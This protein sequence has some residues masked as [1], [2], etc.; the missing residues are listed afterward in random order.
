[1]SLPTPARLP[2]VARLSLPLLLLAGVLALARPAAAQTGADAAAKPPAGRVLPGSRFDIDA[3]LERPYTPEVPFGG[4]GARLWATSPQGW[5]FPEGV[6]WLALTDIPALEL[7]VADAHSRLRPT[8]ATS[9]PSHVHLEGAERTLTATASSGHRA[10]DLQ[11]PLTPPFQPEKRWTSGASG[12]RKDWY[13]VSFGAPRTLR[14]LK[15]H[16]VDD[17]GTG[18]IRPPATV[19]VEAAQP[20]GTWAPVEVAATRPAK[21]AVGANELTFAAPVTAEQIRVVFAR[22]GAKDVTG[23]AGFEPLV[24]GDAPPAPAVKLVADKFLTPDD[25]LVTVLRATNPTDQPTTLRV[26]PV[27]GWEGQQDYRIL[28]NREAGKDGPAGTWVLEGDWRTRYHGFD[29]RQG[30]RFAVTSEPAV[31]QEIHESL[32]VTLADSAGR[33]DNAGFLRARLP[34]TYTLAPGETKIFR[35]A[36][37]FKRPEEPSTLDRVLA[38]SATFARTRRE[39]GRLGTLAV[40]KQDQRD[41]LADQ[42]QATAAWFDASVPYFDCSDE[43]VRKLYY[44]RAFLLRKNLLDPKL[45]ALKHPTFSAGR[46]RSAWD[47]NV[48]SAA[49]GHQIREARWLRDPKFWRGHLQTWAENARPDGVY[50]GQ[51]TPA[52]PGDG[53]AA[54]W[55]TATAWDGHL[56]HPSREALAPL[57]ST[58]AASV[59]GAQKAFDPDDDGLLRADSHRSVGLPYQPAFFAAGNFKLSADLQ[60]PAVPASLERVDR[61]AYQY[62]NAVAVAKLYRLLGQAEP[63]KEFEALAAKIQKAM[64]TTMWRP[65]GKFFFALNAEDR[66]VVDVKEIAGVAPFYVGLAPVGQGFEAAWASILDP[67]QFWTP[68]PVAS[69]SRQNPAYSQ[70]GWPQA[71]TPVTPGLA[72]GP[73]WPHANAIVLSAMA[74]TLRSDR[75]LTGRAKESASPLTRERLWELFS[76]FTKA[77]FRDQDLVQPWTGVVYNGV[78]G[79]W[80]TAERDDLQSTWLDVLIPDL[81]GLVPREDEI[82]ELDPLLPPEALGHFVLDGVRYH[83]HDVTVVWDRPDE[84]D[85]FDDGREGLD[86]YLDGKRVASAQALGP[87]RVDLKT[88]KPVAAPAPAPAAAPGR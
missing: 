56:V 69:A 2:V 66:A 23:L 33:D 55:I 26:M 72:N 63:A 21:P 39:A 44:H 82:L 52:G 22:A 4:V 81:I 49:A 73:T 54:D 65:E 27:P 3:I 59:R 17:T 40:A 20:D 75:T 61:T 25:M 34:F 62:S 88:G 35:A 85:Q 60:E 16:F 58:L 9:T 67:E 70:D 53:Q 43:F 18:S 29:V 86:L 7:E 42:V 83:G 1:M 57:I 78:G 5:A 31:D 32:R 79:Q 45:G 48:L 12:R 46:W 28:S 13:A 36:L 84:A 6:H 8:L 64:T 10:E 15:L 77:Q 24:E 30:L 50:P 68:W 71:E 87:L 41:I 38:A 74:R 11:A 19:T 80:Q 47:S 37:E 76:S 51:I 14:G